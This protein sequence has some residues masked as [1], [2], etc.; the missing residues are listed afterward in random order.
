MSAITARLAIGRTWAWAATLGSC[1]LGEGTNSQLVLIVAR[2][3]FLAK[4][5]AVRFAPKALEWIGKMLPLLSGAIYIHC[6]LCH[7]I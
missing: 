3:F 4:Y 7:S 5:G 1:F 2:G 6:F